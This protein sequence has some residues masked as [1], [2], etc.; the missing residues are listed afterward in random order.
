M[1]VSKARIG[2]KPWV[3]FS[4]IMQ[5]VVKATVGFSFGRK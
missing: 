4:I 2:G 3:A 5:G 1:N